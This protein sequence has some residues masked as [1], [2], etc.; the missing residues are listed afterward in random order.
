MVPIPPSIV[1]Y[2]H[3]GIPG[4]SAGLSPGTGMVEEG[5][6]GDAEQGAE[7]AGLAGDEG[8]VAV[9]FT[10]GVGALAFS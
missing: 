4:G 7:E 3:L 8:V 1:P 9:T 2:A 6:R 10:A 5:R